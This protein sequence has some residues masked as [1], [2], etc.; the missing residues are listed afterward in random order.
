MK[1]SLHR[2]A[3]L[4]LLGFPLVFPLGARA[5]DSDPVVISPAPETGDAAT[6]EE[7]AQTRAENRR[8]ANEL[9]LARRTIGRLNTELGGLRGKDAENAAINDLHTKLASTQSALELLTTKNQQL[10]SNYGAILLRAKESEHR[11]AELRDQLAAAKAAPPAPDLSGKLA[12]TEAKLATTLHS[13]SQLQAENST[14]KTAAADA[15]RLSTELKQASD[16][17]AAAE[18]KLAAALAQPSPDLTAKLAE[19]EDK[20]ATTLRSFSQLESENVRLKTD[21]ADALRL[22][23]DLKNVLDE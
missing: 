18:A 9:D 1:N 8:L 23:D 17:K 15:D 5:A 10:E 2:L 14:L 19:T 3:A 16:A 4:C 11:E 12:E 7:L 6:R 20:L 22:S 13:F 21:A